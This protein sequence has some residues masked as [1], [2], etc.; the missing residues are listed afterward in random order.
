ME[1]DRQDIYQREFKVR[2]MDVDLYRRMRL[3][4]MFTMFQDAAIE[5]TTQLGAGR[6]KTL[7]KGL[8]WVVTHQYAR[9]IRMPEYDEKLVMKSWP[10]K[11]IH[12]FFPR[13]CQITDAEG[14]VLVSSSAYWVLMDQK[15]RKAAFPEEHEIVLEGAKGIPEIPV[16]KTFKAEQTDGE[17]I[18]TVPYSYLDLN[19]HMNNVHYYDLA[20]D[21]LPQEIHRENITEI[22]TEY[23]GEA[24]LGEKIRLKYGK[25]DHTYYLSGEKEKTVFRMKIETVSS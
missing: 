3:S 4:A 8:L 14:Q 24:R 7:D 9:I 12:L 25:Q 15:T 18:F 16:Q 23:I 19:G 21:H 11:T 22:V 17:T 5:H 6:E 20:M 1:T 13:F 10:G 2:S